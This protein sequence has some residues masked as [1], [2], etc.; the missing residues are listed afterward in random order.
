MVQ[1][2]QKLGH[3]EKSSKKQQKNKLDPACVP[4]AEGSKSQN[5]GYKHTALAPGVVKA[6]RSRGSLS[7]IRLVYLLSEHN[8]VLPASKGNSKGNTWAHVQFSPVLQRPPQ[9]QPAAPLR[10]ITNFYHMHREI[11]LFLNG[12]QAGQ[13]RAICSQQRQRQ[14]P[15]RHTCSHAS[16]LPFA[17]GLGPSRQP[18]DSF[19]VCSKSHILLFIESRLGSLR[20]NIQS[21]RKQS[22]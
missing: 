9:G 19:K 14:E 20:R 11:C 7:S 8:V 10:K 15:G 18:W 5:S 17:G 21:P 6:T 4:D 13:P 22:S 2:D 12:F 3:V 1:V 16:A